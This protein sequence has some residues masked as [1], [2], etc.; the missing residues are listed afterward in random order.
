MSII[1]PRTLR[2]IVLLGLIVGTLACTLTLSTDAALPPVHLSLPTPTPIAIPFTSSGP[3]INLNVSATQGWQATGVFVEAGEKL[4][5][6]DIAGE[7]ID[8]KVTLTDGSGYNYVCGHANCCEPLPTARRGALLGRLGGATF[9]IGNGGVFTI[10]S[11][12]ELSL[13]LNDCDEGLYDNAGS[14][15]V[16]LYK[17]H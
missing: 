16:R 9:L 1:Y 8:L 13:R 4:K 10:E 7:I 12:G 15:T 17:G 6:E 3:A 5:V 14:L 2:R 11:S